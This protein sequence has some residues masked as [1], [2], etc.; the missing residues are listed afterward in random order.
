MADCCPETNLT[1]HKV[2]ANVWLSLATEREPCTAAPLGL[3]PVG[4]ITRGK[5]P[6]VT[7]F[8]IVS[9]PAIIGIAEDT[10]GIG[11]WGYK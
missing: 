1:L 8:S 11:G 10:G 3:C 2:Q 4:Q 6:G 5:F 7:V 9:Q